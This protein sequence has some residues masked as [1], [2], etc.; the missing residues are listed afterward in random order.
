[1]SAGQNKGE[2]RRVTSSKHYIPSSKGVYYINSK[3][4]DQSIAKTK[5][6]YIYPMEN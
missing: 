3:Y 6:S 5:L 1:V 4:I 2:K